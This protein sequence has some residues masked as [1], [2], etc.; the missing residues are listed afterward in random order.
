MSDARGPPTLRPW[1]P[2]RRRPTLEQEGARPSRP[3][4]PTRLPAVPRSDRSTSPT[5][6]L[7]LALVAGGALLLL[8]RGSATPCDPADGAGCPA[9]LARAGAAAT[10]RGGPPRLSAQEACRGVS[11]LCAELDTA[12]EMNIRRWRVFEGVMV[13]H[14]PLPDLPDRAQAYALRSAATAGIRLWN[15]QPFPIL[16]DE[17]GTREAQVEVRWVPALEGAQIGLATTVWSPVSGLSVRSLELVTRSPLSG[18]AL[19]PRDVR[20]TAAHEMGHAL[21]LPHSND[22]RDLMYPANTATSLTAGDYRAL[23]A[24][25]AF[26]DGTVIVR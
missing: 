5:A 23:E 15:G 26:E 3:P 25:Y 9:A 7:A 16:V 2:A 17:R 24:L 18:G 13:V 12:R 1:S 11:Y 22:P 8:G 20:L 6:L 10:V 14:V 4:S 21:G 19:D